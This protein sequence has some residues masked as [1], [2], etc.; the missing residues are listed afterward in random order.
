MRHS[1]TVTTKGPGLGANDQRKQDR[2]SDNGGFR[3]AEGKHRMEFKQKG[4]VS[5]PYSDPSLETLGLVGLHTHTHSHA[6][7][8]THTQALTHIHM[9]SHALTHTHVLS[10]TLTQVLTHIL[11]Y[12]YTLTHTYSHTHTLTHAH[13]LSHVTDSHMLYT[14]S[15]IHSTHT[16]ALTHTLTHAHTQTHIL[17]HIY[18]H[19][20]THSHPHTHSHTC[21]THCHTHALTYML[22]HTFTLSHTHILTHTFTTLQQCCLYYRSHCSRGQRLTELS[23][24]LGHSHPHSPTASSQAAPLEISERAEDRPQRE[25]MKPPWRWVGETA[26]QVKAAG[27]HAYRTEFNWGDT[28]GRRRNL[29]PAHCP[30]AFT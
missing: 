4:D 24:P 15:H 29:T 3:N 2:G 17:T 14:H 25:L 10:H 6:H 8:L 18:A 7:S 27:P 23:P 26:Q 11:T 1:A 28:R 16:H 13:T 30:L 22:S 5:F 12:T 19:C 20:H 21:S 9:F